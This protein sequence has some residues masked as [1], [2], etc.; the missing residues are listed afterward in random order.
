MSQGD[1]EEQA[2]CPP[3]DRFRHVLGQARR[4]G[5]FAKYRGLLHAKYCLDPLHLPTTDGG[6]VPRTSSCKGFECPR[7]IGKAR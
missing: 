1:V 2:S 5:L 3:R 7:P 6:P 4:E